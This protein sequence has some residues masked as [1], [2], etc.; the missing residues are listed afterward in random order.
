MPEGGVAMSDQQY[1]TNSITI[2]LSWLPTAGV[3]N[4]TVSV[5]PELVSGQSAFTVILPSLSLSVCYKIEY[6][7]NIT[8][9]NCAGRSDALSYLFTVGTQ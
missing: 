4:Y 3:D 2:A 1:D 9:N 6:S 7:V 8:A 5:L